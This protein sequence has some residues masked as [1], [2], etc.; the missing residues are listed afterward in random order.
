MK[1]LR[2]GEKNKEKP[3]ILDKD[4]NL[5]DISKHINDL[6]PTHLNFETF[7]KIKQIDLSSQPEISNNT[8]TVSYTHLTLPTKRIV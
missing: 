1:L 5:R 4:G 2:L 8:R 6:D 3:A 7:E